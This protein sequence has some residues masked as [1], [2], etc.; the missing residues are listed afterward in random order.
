MT[1]TRKKLVALAL[2]GLLV[3]CSGDDLPPG[4]PKPMGPG[5]LAVLLDSPNNNDGALLFT[6]SGGPTDSLRG[7]GLRVINSA[8]GSNERRVI[9]A[10]LVSSGKV[11]RF[12]VPELGDVDNYTVVLEQAA[13]R[14]QFA[15]QDITNYSL[16]VVVD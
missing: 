9:V 5:L 7:G 16:S 8:A 3:G 13:Q 2:V 10:G 11:L 6:L 4:P 15:Q 14:A 12:W 1:L